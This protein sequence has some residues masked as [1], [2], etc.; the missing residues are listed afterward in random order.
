MRVNVGRYVP[1]DG[2]H[3]HAG[4]A[5]V[6]LGSGEEGTQVVE[7]DLVAH[8]KVFALHRPVGPGCIGA[9]G[10]DV[11]AGVVAGVQRVVHVVPA[12]DPTHDLLHLGVVAQ[13]PGTHPL[14]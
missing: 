8:V 10:D 6:C 12:P 9:F 7:G 4:I 3:D 13:V 14:P 5:L 11:D 1:R 2:G